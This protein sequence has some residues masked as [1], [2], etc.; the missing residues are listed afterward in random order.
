L[1]TNTK[2]SIFTAL[3]LA[4]ALKQT[5]TGTPNGKGLPDA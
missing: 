2:K 3:L 1:K 4:V 5:D